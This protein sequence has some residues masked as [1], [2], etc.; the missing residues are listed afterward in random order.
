MP[1]GPIRWSTSLDASE[2][3]SDP[4]E[5]SAGGVV[6]RPTEAGSYEVALAKQV[7][8]NTGK[9]QIRLP[10]GHIDPGESAEE[11]AVREVEEEVG[12]TARVVAPL[13]DAS[14]TF[15]EKKRKV[16]IAKVVHYFLMAWEDGDGHPADGEMDTVF[17]VPLA[18]AALDFD[19]EQAAIERARTLLDSENPPNL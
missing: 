17:W 10:K 11:A 16:H 15:Y 14:Y 3:G 7:D 1:A 6:V 8:R 18:E 12:L 2:T 19:S 5:V 13:T 9:R 4:R